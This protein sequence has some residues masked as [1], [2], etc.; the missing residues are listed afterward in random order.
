MTIIFPI[1]IDLGAKN[2]GFY[3]S[4]YRK[5]ECPTNEQID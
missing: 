4:H 5:D 3:L 2:T 1:C